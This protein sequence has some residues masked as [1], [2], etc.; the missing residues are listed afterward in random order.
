MNTS[1][2]YDFVVEVKSHPA[3]RENSLEFGL[4]MF[5]EENAQVARKIAK[6]VYQT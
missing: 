3:H 1:L 2:D 6:V 5:L 4:L